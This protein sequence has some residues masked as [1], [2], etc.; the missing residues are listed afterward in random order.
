MMVDVE[1]AAFAEVFCGRG[2]QADDGGTFA[3]LEVP[4]EDGAREAPLDGPLLAES[5]LRAIGSG[6]LPA[7]L[8]LAS[9]GAPGVN[10]D[11]ESL[12]GPLRQLTGSRRPSGRFASI[13]GLD[14][15]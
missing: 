8:L 13:N 12:P 6:I 2:V 3:G 14:V 10:A 4:N 9:I 15:V 11:D 5:A 7:D 1:G